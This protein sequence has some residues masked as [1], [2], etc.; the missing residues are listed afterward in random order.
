MPVTK[1]AHCNSDF[2]WDW[3]DAFLKF[4]F[5]DGADGYL[6]GV[7]AN[8]LRSGGYVVKVEAW[9]IHNEVIDSIAKAGVEL[10]PFQ[11]I[12]Y[13]YDNPRDYLPKKLVRLLDRLLPANGEAVA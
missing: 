1:C 10:I 12:R 2:Q 5:G 8:A 4:G 6:T 13:G 3:E 7:V 9:G 11:R